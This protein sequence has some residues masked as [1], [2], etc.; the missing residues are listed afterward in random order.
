MSRERAQKGKVRA[1]GGDLSMIVYTSTK[2]SVSTK[3]FA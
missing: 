3:A 1:S 2:L